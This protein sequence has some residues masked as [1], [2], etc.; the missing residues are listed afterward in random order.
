M[1][2]IGLCLALAT[3]AETHCRMAETCSK[4]NERATRRGCS[5]NGY[6]LVGR[7]P[8]LDQ[9]FWSERATCCL[10]QRRERLVPCF[11]VV[12]HRFALLVMRK[13]RREVLSVVCGHLHSCQLQR[14]LAMCHVYV[15]LLDG[16]LILL[17]V[18]MLLLF[19][20]AFAF[21]GPNS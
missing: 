19:V 7:R 11:G 2:P 14:L 3:A 16:L 17:I 18:R 9:L 4:E 15:Y 20:R 13:E 5:N 1:A 12:S 8:P 10:H 21:V 6:T